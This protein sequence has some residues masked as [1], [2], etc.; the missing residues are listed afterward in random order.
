MVY[1]W[2][3]VYGVW[4]GPSVLSCGAWPSS[5]AMRCEAPRQ[6]GG[7]AAGEVLEKGMGQSLSK[8]KVVRYEKMEK[9]VGGL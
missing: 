9:D 6:F 2:G 4:L 5:A 7:I 1:C 8:G 3:G